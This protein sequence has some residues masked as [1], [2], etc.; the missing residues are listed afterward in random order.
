M[1]T[2][3]LPDSA[4]FLSLS[5]FAFLA[6]L[7]STKP[8]AETV[9]LITN[10][11]K[12][13]SLHPEGNPTSEGS[14]PRF[15]FLL[16]DTILLVL[17]VAEKQLKGESAYLSPQLAGLRGYSLPVSPGGRSMRQLVM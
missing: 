14:L 1:T 7:Y 5:L 17:P 16:S 15:A 3:H 8:L 9:S 6:W 11:N 2:W 10:G 4:F 13:Y 12:A